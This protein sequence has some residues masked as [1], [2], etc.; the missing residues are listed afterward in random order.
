[1]PDY[2]R[3]LWRPFTAISTRRTCGASRG[4]LGESWGRKFRMYSLS[5][6]LTPEAA[7]F[8]SRGSWVRIPPP[9]PC[10][11]GKF[12]VFSRNDNSHQTSRTPLKI[13]HFHARSIGR[14]GEKWGKPRL[15]LNPT[16]VLGARA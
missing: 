15:D 1:M 13:P 16:I 5:S 2:L 14:V 3:M 10:F 12:A 9:R 7:C 6:V 8:G 4:V 11:P